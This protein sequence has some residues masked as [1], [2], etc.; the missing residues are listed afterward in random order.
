MYLLNVCFID[1]FFESCTVYFICSH[2][3][4]GSFMYSKIV[5]MVYLSNF[6]F[7]LSGVQGRDFESCDLNPCDD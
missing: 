4:F 2:A 1:T 5:I 3:I 7:Y 6:F